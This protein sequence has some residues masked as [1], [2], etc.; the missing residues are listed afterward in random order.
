MSIPLP[1]INLAESMSEAAEAGME[2]LTTP[3]FSCGGNHLLRQLLQPG[4]SPA[5][6]MQGLAAQLL[7]RS[8]VVT[9]MVKVRDVSLGGCHQ[10]I[11]C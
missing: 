3:S 8:Q 10:S 11:T 1:Q 7:E 6:L 5:Q 4:V 2:K 9:K